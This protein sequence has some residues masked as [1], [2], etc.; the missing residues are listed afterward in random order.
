MKK[1]MK[2][3]NHKGEKIAEV[4]IVT[5]ETIAEAVKTLTEKVALSKVNR[6]HAQDT[7]NEKRGSLT[8]EQSPMAKLNKLAKDNPKLQAEI[9]ALIAA[10]TPK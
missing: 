9:D 2:P 5:F 4:E 7:M 1:E 6:Q 10:N 8:R 3:V